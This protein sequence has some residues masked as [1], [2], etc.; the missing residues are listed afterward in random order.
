MQHP[1][2]QSWTDN[3][4][5][6]E[7][8]HKKIIKF[9][10]TR[11]KFLRIFWFEL[12]QNIQSQSFV[13]G[14]S[15]I[16]W[17]VNPWSV[18]GYVYVYLARKCDYH[19]RHVW[20]LCYIGYS[21]QT[22]S[23]GQ[24]PTVLHCNRPSILRGTDFCRIGAAVRARPIPAK[25]IFA[26]D[27]IRLQDFIVGV[28]SAVLS[29]WLRIDFWYFPRVAAVHK[30]NSVS[31]LL[32][33][34]EYFDFNGNSLLIV[35]SRSPTSSQVQLWVQH[36]PRGSKGQWLNVDQGD[37]L[38]ISKEKG[39][40]LRLILAVPPDAQLDPVVGS[41]DLQ[42][43]ARGL[44]ITEGSFSL[45]VGSIEAGID[46]IAGCDSFGWPFYLHGGQIGEGRST[47]SVCILQWSHHSQISRILDT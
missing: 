24:L 45:Q 10:K 28:Y 20:K 41:L 19:G 43:I 23:N 14:T 40:K 2:S 4:S 36:K 26:D 13:P 42:S 46:W 35:S 38:R 22:G 31:D 1:R 47:D 29:G 11:M 17:A 12:S 7:S 5:S 15:S 9:E 27:W 44:S 6:T 37:K 25:K 16:L 8:K 30:S 34:A 33:S 39:K 32:L 21:L 3:E 18:C